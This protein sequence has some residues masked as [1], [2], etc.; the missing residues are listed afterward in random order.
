MITP[1]T[2]ENASCL[3]Q[4]QSRDS[5]GAGQAASMR[6]PASRHLHHCRCSVGIYE[7][8]RRGNF[9]FAW[10][11]APQSSP[12]AKGQ[13][14]EGR[15]GFPK[16]PSSLDNL[17]LSSRAQPRDQFNPPPQAT[18][19]TGPKGRKY[20]SRGSNPRSLS[21]SNRAKTHH[22]SCQTHYITFSKMEGKT[23]NS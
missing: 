22:I 23:L 19:S 15:R 7:V 16:R 5:H 3:C 9:V 4:N 11:L 20:N 13:Y 8:T 1:T 6:F 18:L 17:K 14:P 12:P 2:I 10:F 21:V